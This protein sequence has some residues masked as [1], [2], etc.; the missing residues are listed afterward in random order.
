MDVARSSITSRHKSLR[1]A[2]YFTGC[3]VAIALITAGL[4]GL[5][6]AVPAVDRTA[7]QID[8][9]KRGSLRREVSGFGTLVPEDVRWISATTQ[10]RVDRFILYP[11]AS[12][13]PG[14]MI[15]EL[16]NPQ[17]D[18]ELQD[19]QLR[20]Q[21]AEAALTNLRVQMQ[22]DYLQQKAAAAAIRA[23]Y[24]K[25]KMQAEMNEALA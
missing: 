17:L 16:S 21:A 23:E 2:M 22:N 4:A 19:A 8:T 7:L 6:P 9:V 5:K 14:S 15:L 24:T 3:V 13:A 12:V 11:G 25:A 18:L 10:G 1:R 20:V